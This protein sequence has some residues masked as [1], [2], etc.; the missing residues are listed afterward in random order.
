[1]F[2]VFCNR[3]SRQTLT[4][5]APLIG[6]SNCSFFIDIHSTA[7]DALVYKLNLYRLR[8]N[9]EIQVKNYKTVCLDLRPSNDP[10][11]D[12]SA[13]NG[14]LIFH[15]RRLVKGYRSIRIYNLNNEK[16]F[17]FSARE[18]WDR[19]RIAYGIAESGTDFVLGDVF[20]HDINYDKIHGISFKKG[21]Y[22]GQEVVSRMHHRGIVRKRVLVARGIRT[23]PLGGAVIEAAGKPVGRLGTVVGVKAIALVRIDH[24]K[25][26]MNA[27]TPIT[28]HCT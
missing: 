17:S 18:K 12:N 6:R 23:L 1:M 16:Q 24:I 27:N 3:S 13:Q 22:I 4:L 5:L 25:A 26:M 10:I 28:A 14:E 9:V 20:P 11:K 2:F 7:A 21:C 15:D 19:I 8:A